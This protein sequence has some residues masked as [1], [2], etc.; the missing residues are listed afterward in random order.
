MQIR[1]R[2]R[3]G[4][5]RNRLTSQVAGLSSQRGRRYTPCTDHDERG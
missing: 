5:G 3:P 4:G 1:V 2:A